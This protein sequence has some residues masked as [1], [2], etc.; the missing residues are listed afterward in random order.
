MKTYSSTANITGLITEIHNVK[1]KLFK[2]QKRRWYYKNELEHT[3]KQ[4][5]AERK[6]LTATSIHCE[7]LKEDKHNLQCTNESLRSKMITKDEQITN[8]QENLKV[9]IQRLWIYQFLY[10]ISLLIILYLTWN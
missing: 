7:E 1:D 3:R 2:E 6:A 10:L 8:Y 5:K 4:S 9:Y